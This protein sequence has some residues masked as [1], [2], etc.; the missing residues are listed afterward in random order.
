M[1]H[2]QNGVRGTTSKPISELSSKKMANP[3]LPCSAVL[4]PGNHSQDPHVPSSSGATT[5][6]ALLITRCTHM[7]HRWEKTVSISCALLPYVC[8]SPPR[9]TCHTC[10]PS[11]LLKG[12]RDSG[13]EH[14][15]PVQPKV[16]TPGPCSLP[17]Q[18]RDQPGLLEPN[19]PAVS[20]SLGLASDT[21]CE[22]AASA[23]VERI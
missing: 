21:Q 5:P 6:T 9:A 4:D 10:K 16:D 17:F 15:L 13:T 19:R 22:L 8:L 14:P 20:L 23:C 11:R 18:T 7:L 12:N 2:Q 1:Q 3:V